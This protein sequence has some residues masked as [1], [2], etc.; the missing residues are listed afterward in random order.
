MLLLRATSPL[1]SSLFTTC[2][3]IL[4]SRPLSHTATRTLPRPTSLLFRRTARPL[5]VAL[6]LSLPF[7]TPSRPTLHDSSPA[8]A[9]DGAGFSSSAG[10]G[11]KK[12]VPVF[13][14]GSLNPSAIKQ[15]SLGGMLGLAAGVVLSMFSRMLVLLLGVGIVLQQV[16]SLRWSET[17]AAVF[18]SQKI[19]RRTKWH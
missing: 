19:I 5:V 11:G 12:D 9:L 1:R 17:L 10:V 13:K 16:S 7:L 14:D 2:T 6:G 3:P 4:L 8:A 15:I 18:P